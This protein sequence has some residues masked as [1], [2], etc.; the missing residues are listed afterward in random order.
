MITILLSLCMM[1]LM[2]TP[3]KTLIQHSLDPYAFNDDARPQITPFFTYYTNTPEVDPY[4]HQFYRNVH[5]PIGFTIL[6]RTVGNIINPK[7]VSKLLP[8]FLWALIL[9]SL[10]KTAY[11]LGGTK[12]SLIILILACLSP[13]F[14]DRLAGG[15]PRSFAFPGLALTVWG[16]SHKKW[17][18]STAAIILTTAFYPV[19]G[20]IGSTWLF[21]S[22]LLQGITSNIPLNKIFLLKAG[23]LLIGC[24][25][26]QV[27]ILSPQLAQTSNYGN[28][29]FSHETQA[30]PEISPTCRWT[31]GYHLPPHPSFL[32]SLLPY[33]KKAVGWNPTV[34]IPLSPQALL[35]IILSPTFL[36]LICLCC[37]IILVPPT[38]MSLEETWL[39]LT[40]WSIG[41]IIL[42]TISSYSFPLL[43]SPERYLQF[44]IPIL[45][46]L[47]I[48]SL[49]NKLLSLKT[50]RSL[51]IV[52]AIT[53]GIILTITCQDPNRYITTF[54]QAHNDKELYDYVNTLPKNAMIA[55]WPTGP[56]EN[57]P[58]LTG[59]AVLLT[60]EAHQPYYT[61]Y[62]LTMRQRLNTFIKAMYSTSKAPLIA[63]NK[64]GITDILIDIRHFQTPPS[65]FEPFQSLIEKEVSQHK[66]YY[67]L[68]HLDQL[69]RF[70]KGPYHI[71]NLEHL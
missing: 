60:F 38:L 66:T 1:A 4:I 49:T 7:I 43:Y 70:N 59:R 12:A 41:L 67:L 13:I 57:I 47:W 10:G 61:T 6:Y 33:I 68:T 28:Y 55:G 45:G 9:L 29:I 64:L 53:L 46:L 19:A 50:T 18:F 11:K 37:L 44:G 16:L 25:L 2:V 35:K 71:I 51:Q 17:R 24:L 5:H 15:L 23:G 14:W 62:T 3:L 20:A 40:S 56:I 69:S 27:L 42:H 8:F 65:Y 30:Y 54:I 22:L 48:A 63:L 21:V 36:L 31:S 32:K 39:T 52:T 34:N 26:L 58:Y